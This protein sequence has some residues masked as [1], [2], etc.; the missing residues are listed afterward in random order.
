[1]VPVQ[2]D[3]AV[4]VLFNIYY[5]GARDKSSK[6]GMPYFILPT[7]PFSYLFP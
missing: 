2:M 4:W 7:F 6:L 3:M 1:M 5:K